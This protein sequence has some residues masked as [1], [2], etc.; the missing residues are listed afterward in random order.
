M[1]RAIGTVYL[2]IRG[3]V[4]PLDY[5]AKVRAED[6]SIASSKLFLQDKIPL[7]M[8]ILILAHTRL[9]GPSHPE[10]TPY[11]FP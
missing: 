5:D 9:P 6:Y 4:R 11:Q 7:F 3:T 8:L 1:S 2:L 10:D